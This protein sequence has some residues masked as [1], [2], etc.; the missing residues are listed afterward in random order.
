MAVNDASGFLAP[1]G[2][3]ETLAGEGR[4]QFGVNPSAAKQANLRPSA[5]LSKFARNRRGAPK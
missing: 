3:I 5:N 2:V 4:L 1:E